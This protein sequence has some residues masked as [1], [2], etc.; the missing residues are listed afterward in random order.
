MDVFIPVTSQV[1]VKVGDKVRACETVIAKM[2][3]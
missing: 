2:K 3:K 1:N